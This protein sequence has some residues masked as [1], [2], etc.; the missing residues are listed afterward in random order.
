MCTKP[1]LVFLPQQPEADAFLAELRRLTAESGEFT[2]LTPGIA[3]NFRKAVSARQKRGDMEVQSAAA[4]TGKCIASAAV[5]ETE[6][7]VLLRYPELSEEVF[8]P[9]TLVIRYGKR[10]EMMRAAQALEGH[11]TATL[12]GAAEDLAEYSDLVAILERKA[13]RLIFNA[14]P[15]GVEVAHAMIHGGPYPSASDSRSTSVGSQAILRFARPVCYQGFPGTA[16]PEELRNGN[17]LGILRK[18]NGSLTRE[19]VLG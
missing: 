19:P 7:D 13:G 17:P 18:V 1:G 9:S 4:D 11:L 5:M 3:A 10:E 16:L 12:V 15:T 14:F 6:I 2:L 8:G